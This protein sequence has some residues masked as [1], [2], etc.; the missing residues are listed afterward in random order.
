[1]GINSSGVRQ[2]AEAAGSGES[3]RI[4]QDRRRAAAHIDGARPARRRP[5]RRVP[6]SRVGVDV[7]QR[8]SSPVPWRCWPWRSGCRSISDGQAA[9]IQGMRRIGDL[10]RISVFSAFFGA[11][12]SVALVYFLR[13]DGVVPSLV[14]AA[15]LTVGISWW[16]RRKI[17]IPAASVTVAAGARRG[18]RRC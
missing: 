6:P 7:R 18:R 4:A 11:V 2:I 15:A 17:E 16:Y 3:A 12:V 8:R 13:E 10:A 5:A 14:A 9:L 1:M